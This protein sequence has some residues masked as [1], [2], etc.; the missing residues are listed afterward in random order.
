MPQRPSRP[1]RAKLCNKTTRERHG[2]CEEHAHLHSG[3][4]RH[5]RGKSSTKR[6]Y[7]GRWRKLRDQ[8]M[9]RD[10]WL[11]QE[12][13]RQGRATPAHA[14]DHIV[15]KAEGGSDSPDNLQAL[16]RTC[17]Q[18]KTQQEAARARPMDA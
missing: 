14:V 12:C 15:N 1:C 16:C 3:W 6:G 13:L 7:G 18:A 5:H 9:R 17:H 2:Y 8:V 10:K 11:C 4:E